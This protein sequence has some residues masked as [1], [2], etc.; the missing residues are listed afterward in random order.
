MKEMPGLGILK[1]IKRDRIREATNRRGWESMKKILVME[2]D[3]WGS[4]R[5]PSKEVLQKL[6]DLGDPAG[7]DPFT[8]WDALESEKDI[9]CLMDLM[10]EFSDRRGHPA[11][12]TMNVAVANPDFEK[13][14]ANGFKDYY[15]ESF[16]ETYRRY[17]EHE[18]SFLRWKEGVK[19]GVFYPQLHC[20][21]H[22]N[23][24]RW[25]NDLS[26]GKEDVR[27]AFDHRMIS[28]GASVTPTNRY[29]YMDSF[30]YDS[31][32][33]LAS[34]KM[35]VEEG[36][37][38]FQEIFGYPSRSLI[39]SCYIWDEELE[40]IFY[41]TGIEYIQGGRIQLKPGRR[42]GTGGLHRQVH[43]MGEKNDLGQYYLI[44][45]CKFEPS[46]REDIDWVESCLSD[47]ESAFHWKRPAII[48]THRL[49]Y[50]GFIDER[51][52]KRNLEFLHQLISR[53]MKKWPDLEFYHSV[54]LGGEMKG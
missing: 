36:A 47:M 34:L 38:L 40:R 22:I 6:T 33:E 24:H 13:I 31:K 17:P 52:R 41:D 37:K 54:E 42:V 23:V 18:G 32:E 27:L 15:Y 1:K 28:V 14:E 5:T 12:M 9:Q 50:I 46:W 8:R 26:N 7:T 3:D 44:R 16:P 48:G 20:R 25:M 29:A 45:N 4:I 30:N 53:A 2:S 51:N 43:H 19:K 49:N 35:I 11:V 10:T 21:E 39:P